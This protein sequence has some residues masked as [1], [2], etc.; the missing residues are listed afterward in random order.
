MLQAFKVS[1]LLGALGIFALGFEDYL[2]IGHRSFVLYILPMPR[3]I[4]GLLAPSCPPAVRREW[5]AL[6]AEE[7]RDAFFDIYHSKNRADLQLRLG[8]MYVLGRRGYVVGKGLEGES[9]VLMDVL[10][11]SAIAAKAVD[12]V[13]NKDGVLHGY[14]V[15][16][17]HSDATM[18]KRFALFFGNNP[19]H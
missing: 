18:R 8:E 9:L 4:L 11:D 13:V 16:G 6:L 2:V 3:A 10:D 12:T 5:N 17:P 15:D 14:F 1:I 7:G 19:L